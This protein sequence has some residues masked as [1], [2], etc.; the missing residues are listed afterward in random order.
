MDGLVDASTFSSSGPNE[1]EVVFVLD[2]DLAVRES[3]K[4][5]LE[6]EGLTVEA[7]ASTS[8][9]LEHPNLMRAGCLVFDPNLPSM[10]DGFE[11]LDHLAHRKANLPVIVITSRAT[12]GLRRRSGA[13]GISQVLEK[14]LF[15]RT[16]VDVVKKALAG[17]GAQGCQAL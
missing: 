8:E 10:D 17:A 15:D 7:C 9:L 3:L 1:H 2:D 16:L 6:L 11:M 12:S 4:F 13:F 14:P 5:A